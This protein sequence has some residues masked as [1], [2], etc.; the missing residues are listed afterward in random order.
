[1]EFLL[2]MNASTKYSKKL[3]TIWIRE[4]IMKLSLLKTIFLGGIK[5]QFFIS[6]SKVSAEPTI[7]LTKRF[8]LIK[9]I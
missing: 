3:F 2:L 4:N 5:W 1:M 7:Y 6:K 8:C 9:N